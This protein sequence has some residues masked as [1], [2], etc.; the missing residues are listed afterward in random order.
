M[1][2]PKIQALIAPL[3][4]PIPSA[5]GVMFYTSILVMTSLL[6]IN[7]PIATFYAICFAV[8]LMYVI[9]GLD[10]FNKI[11]SSLKAKLSIL[12]LSA[13]GFVYLARREDG[14]YK[15]GKTI[16][17]TQRMYAHKSTYQMKFELIKFWHTPNYHVAELAAQELRLMNDLQLSAFIKAFNT[18]YKEQP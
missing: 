6:Y 15:I 12:E 2:L 10:I 5:L 18:Y 16:D 3:S 17:I 14:I 4:A 8:V 9:T 1:N 13:P 7:A 11:I